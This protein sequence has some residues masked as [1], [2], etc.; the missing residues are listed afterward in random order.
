MPAKRIP[1]C[2]FKECRQA[3]QRISG[4]CGFCNGHFC[5]NHRLLEDHKCSNLVDVSTLSPAWWLVGMAGTLPHSR[6]HVADCLSRHSARRRRTKRTQRSSSASAPRSS[7]VYKTSAA[8]T[9]AGRP[10]VGERIGQVSLRTAG[11]D[12]FGLGM[13]IGTRDGNVSFSSTGDTCVARALDHRQPT[14]A[15]ALTA[16][17]PRQH[18]TLRFYEG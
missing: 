17:G 15:G 3:A 9:A 2:D 6:D 4:D 14:K 13:G 7:R 5:N 11:D 12:S 16:D 1:R 8:A 10:T 18:T